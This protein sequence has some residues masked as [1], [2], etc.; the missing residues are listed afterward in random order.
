M[1]DP[2]DRIA[3]CLK[4]SRP[5]KAALA[6]AGIVTFADLSGWLRPDVAAL[7]GIGP[8]SFLELDPAMT[9]RGLGYKLP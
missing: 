4:L 3:D 9:A 2:A 7:H 1:T 6:Q 5:A 8:K